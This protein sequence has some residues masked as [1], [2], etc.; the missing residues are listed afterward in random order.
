MTISNIAELLEIVKRPSISHDLGSRLAKTYLN[1]LDMSQNKEDLVK[2]LTRI[3]A[4]PDC[5]NL[6]YI[7]L[8]N[9]LL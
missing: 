9:P 1:A 5:D 4:I 7:M 6:Q 8:Q 2:E 3:A